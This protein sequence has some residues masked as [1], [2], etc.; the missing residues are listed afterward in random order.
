MT[1]V[2]LQGTESARGSQF[3]L[4]V[5]RGIVSKLGWAKGDVLEL[6]NTPDTVLVRKIRSAPEKKYVRYADDEK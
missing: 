3:F 4:T 1:R 5:P 6:T 2:K